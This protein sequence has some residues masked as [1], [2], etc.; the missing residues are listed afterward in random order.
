[1]FLFH[2]GKTVAVQM[3]IFLLTISVRQ[4]GQAA[5]SAMT[6][7]DDRPLDRHANGD[8]NLNLFNTIF[9][10]M[11]SHVL[12]TAFKDDVSAIQWCEFSLSL[13]ARLL[14]ISQYFASFSQ[15]PKL[16]Q[17]RTVF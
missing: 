3:Y 14:N 11:W 4:G 9:P 15:N 13:S 6:L 12:Y 16:L 2:T 8:H 17:W 5:H 1:M 7:E 10:T